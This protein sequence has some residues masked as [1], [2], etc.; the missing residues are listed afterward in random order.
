M[1]NAID[2]NAPIPYPRNSLEQ[3]FFFK[4]YRRFSLLLQHDNSLNSRN[5][6]KKKLKKNTE[7]T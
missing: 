6:K 2:Q 5:P 3:P 4:E 7:I 1:A